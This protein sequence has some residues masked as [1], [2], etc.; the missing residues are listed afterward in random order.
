VAGGVLGFV[1]A[2]LIGMVYGDAH[3]LLS[4]LAL[5]GVVFGGGINAV[6]LHK[7]PK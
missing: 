5:Y 1:A 7:A 2:R 4:S 3:G 6:F